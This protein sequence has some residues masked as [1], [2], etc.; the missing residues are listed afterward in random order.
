MAADSDPFFPYRER[1]FDEL[2]AN[3]EALI[4][5]EG[6]Y[7]R[8]TYE[9]QQIIVGFISGVSQYL[10]NVADQQDEVSK[11]KAN[12]RY[13]HPSG[14]A[15]SSVY[16]MGIAEGFGAVGFL[17]KDYTGRLLGQSLAD[18][19]QSINS[20][21]LGSKKRE[22]LVKQNR[23]PLEN[24]NIL[25]DLGLASNELA[26]YIGSSQRTIMKWMSGITSPS[27]RSGK[28]LTTGLSNAAGLIE[29]LKDSYGLDSEQIT[30]LLRSTANGPYNVRRS[31]I[32][33]IPL[34]DYPSIMEAVEKLAENKTLI[35]QNTNKNDVER[36]G[37]HKLE[38]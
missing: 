34:R 27:I 9:D 36:T 11:Q 14:N 2:G 12:Q 38:N 4:A 16:Y 30:F 26:Y 31:V 5:L 18:E 7:A 10:F 20:S 8:S 6:L 19:N 35:I 24:W 28:A 3:H 33:W 23:S 29:D 15:I 17:L 21:L 22:H 32:D 13:P 25:K 37:L 1:G